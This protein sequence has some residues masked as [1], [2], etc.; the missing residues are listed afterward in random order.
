M[1][2]TISWVPEASQ[3]LKRRARKLATKVVEEEPAAKAPRKHMPAKVTRVAAKASRKV[4][5]KRFVTR[6]CIP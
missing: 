3:K 5:L 6:G 1:V 4:S 2:S